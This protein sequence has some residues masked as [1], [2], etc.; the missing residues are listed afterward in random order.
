MLF[1]CEISGRHIFDLKQRVCRVKEAHFVV[2]RDEIQQPK[3]ATLSFVDQAWTHR[4]KQHNMTAR[5]EPH[6]Y[7]DQVNKHENKIK[8]IMIWVLITE[9]LAIK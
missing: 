3:P 9:K 5:Q 1:H 4:W 6:R 8:F 7:H 2:V